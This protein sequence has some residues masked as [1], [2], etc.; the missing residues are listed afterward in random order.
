MLADREDPN[1]LLYYQFEF[2][3]ESAKFKRHNVAV[4]A[5]QVGRL[6]GL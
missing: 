3:I 2:K 4:L 1:G 5:T 6:L